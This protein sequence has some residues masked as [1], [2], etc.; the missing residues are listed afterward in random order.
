MLVGPVSSSFFDRVLRFAAFGLALL[1]L[2]SVA[3]CESDAN[4][5]AAPERAALGEAKQVRLHVSVS[6]RTGQQ[7]LPEQFA[8]EAPGVDLWQPNIKFGRA[9]RQ[10]PVYPVGKEYELYIY[11]RGEDGPRRQVS[12]SMKARSSSE[13]ALSKTHIEI[14]D[15]SI[16]VTGPAIFGERISMGRREASQT[17]GP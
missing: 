16:I 2:G 17:V 9:T 5:A 6:D 7:P 8:I 1:G 4:R 10:F 3:G 11:P 13:L 12:F 14:Y 15:D